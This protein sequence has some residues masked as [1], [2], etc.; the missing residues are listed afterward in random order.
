MKKFLDSV[1]TI[2]NKKKKVVAIYPE[3]H[4]WPYYTKIRNFV[5]TSFKYPVKLNSPVYSF[6]T[7]YLERKN[8]K[9]KIV[10]Y[11]DGPFY[12]N[13]DLKLRQAQEEL[14]DRVYECMV[15]RSKASNVEYIKYMK[16]EDENYG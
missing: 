8:R 13:K 3:A 16:I 14:R 2:I 6:T 7:T 15:N 5:S 10:I 11:V 4:V 9:P 1:E 12:P